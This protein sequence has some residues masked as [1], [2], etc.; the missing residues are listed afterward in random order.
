M[1]MRYMGIGKLEQIILG[2]T[3][4]FWE[5]VIYLFDMSK[6]MDGGNLV[7]GFFILLFLDGEIL[8]QCFPI[9]N[10]RLGLSSVV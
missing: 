6:L 5:R 8:R 7:E 2:G 10:S 3:L 1:K 9:E 4:R